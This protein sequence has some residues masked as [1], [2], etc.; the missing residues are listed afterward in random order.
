MKR[1]NLRKNVLRAMLSRIWRPTNYLRTT[2]FKSRYRGLT[3]KKC[4]LQ[5]LSKMSYQHQY[6]ENF[7]FAL[8]KISPIIVSPSNVQVIFNFCIAIQQKSNFKVRFFLIIFIIYYF[9]RFLMS[10]KCRYKINSKHIAVEMFIHL[11]IM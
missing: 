9:L 11:E 3:A 8:Y 2:D 4:Q 1:L 6:I 10:V 5:F 7:I